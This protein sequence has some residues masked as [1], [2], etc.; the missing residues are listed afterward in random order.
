MIID[1]D[2]DEV[3]G[4]HMLGYNAD[5]VINLF[6]LAIQHRIKASQLKEALW[7]YPTATSDVISMLG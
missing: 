2:S 6:A 4:A 7:G 1:N 5:E 3:L